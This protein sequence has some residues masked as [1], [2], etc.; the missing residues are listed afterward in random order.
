MTEKSG[1]DAA[2]LPHQ[3]R[4]E[5]KKGANL[6]SV[7]LKRRRNREIGN[8]KQHSVWFIS[9]GMNRLPRNVL[10]NFGLEFPKSDLTVYLPSGIFCQM[11]STP[12]IQNSDQSATLSK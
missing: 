10:L 8:G 11:A 4:F 1:W 6:C 3:L 2:E 12:E 9:T 7:S 5:S